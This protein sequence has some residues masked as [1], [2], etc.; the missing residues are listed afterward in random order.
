MADVISA[1][2]L[3]IGAGAMGMAFAD[4]LLAHSTKTIAIV[5]RNARPGGHWLAA[6]PFVRLHQPAATY[7]V[8]SRRL[9]TDN[10]E[11]SGWNKGLMDCSSKDEI[12]AYFNR[13]M[14]DTFLASGRVQY[15]PKHEYTDQVTSILTGKT[16][17]V[18]PETI[19]VDAT[20]SETVIPT[21]RP[22]PYEVVNGVELVTPTGLAE[23][24]RPYQHY[25]VVG[26]GKTSCDACLFL[27]EAGVEPSRITWIRPRDAY[28]IVRDYFQPDPELMRTLGM[29]FSQGVLQASSWYDVMPKILGTGVLQLLDTEVEPTM[30]HCATVSKA[31]LEALRGI[32][33]VV[34]MGHVKRI[35]RTQV[36]LDNGS[37]TPNPDTLYIDCTACAITKRPGK[38]VFD[39]KHITVQPVR[40]CQQT[41]SAAVIGHVEATYSD[42]KLK[43]QLCLPTILPDWPADHPISVLQ[44][45]TNDYAWSQQPQTVKWMQQCRLDH[46]RIAMKNMKPEDIQ[47]R[48]GGRKMVFG[49]LLKLLENLPADE[50]AKMKALLVVP[51]SKTSHL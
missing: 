11:N 50:A 41:F 21:M 13:V 32:K 48:M 5:D 28:L 2:Y 49:K 30:W 47:T 20:Y 4:T 26:A 16:Y 3:V 31:E 29:G 46:N 22:P 7:G 40:Q 24:I 6:Y 9:E 1:D 35:T 38:R 36:T 18:G 17:R 43:N 39:G 27:L 25:T 23:T 44:S 12:C 8:E 10:V 42:E 51:P 37:Y 19:L 15:F 33:S 34:R 45:S 14:Q